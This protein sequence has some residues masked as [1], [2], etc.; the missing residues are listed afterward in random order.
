M[1][2]LPLMIVIGF[3][4]FCIGGLARTYMNI[5]LNNHFWRGQ[6]R[7]GSTEGRYLHHIRNSGAPVWPLIIGPICMVLGVIV[8]FSAIVYHNRLQLR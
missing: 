4:L 2:N 1:R 5:A 7:K 8:V 3:A 6:W